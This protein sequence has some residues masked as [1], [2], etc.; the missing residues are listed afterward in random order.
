VSRCPTDARHALGLV[1]GLVVG[2]LPVHSVRADP[3]CE[4]ESVP[5]ECVEVEVGPRPVAPVPRSVWLHAPDPSA[6]PAVQSLLDEVLDHVAPA[7]RELMMDS[8]V[9]IHVVP[10]DQN[11]TDLAPW[12]HLR[13]VL[14]PDGSPSD[15]Y[16]EARTYDEVRGI[17]PAACSDGHLD[18][19]I[20]EEQMV[21]F[22][23]GAYRSPGPNDLG[24]NLIHEVGHAVE[25]ALT[26]EQRETLASSYMAARQ[27]FPV[28]IVGSYPA[29]S[30]ADQ[31][32]YF[33]EGTAAWFE[34][35]DDDA[36]TYRRSWLADQ[37]PALHSLLSDVYAVPPPVPECDGL[38]ATSVIETGN[39]VFAG[40]PGPDVIVGSEASDVINGGGGADVICGGGG[41]DVLYGGYGDDR[42]LGGPGDDF[43][44]GGVGDDALI[45]AEDGEVVPGAQDGDPA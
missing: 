40:T 4:L 22:P 45:D 10:R 42:L 14:V 29:Y 2:L 38:R 13:G 19:G 39:R 6:L 8:E 23:D 16:P 9:R 18:I 44:A 12:A 1:A 11:V 7:T 35:G 17:G 31:R 33:A 25:C 37:D 36:S 41:D 34:P 20:A 5:P 15:G 24:R 27:R 30:I 28:D 21:T 43:M 3:G 26:T 32:E